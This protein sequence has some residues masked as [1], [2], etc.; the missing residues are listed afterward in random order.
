MAQSMKVFCSNSSS[1][2]ALLLILM[3]KCD[4]VTCVSRQIDILPP[5]KRV[6]RIQRNNRM[7]ATRLHCANADAIVDTLWRLDF[8]RL[9]SRVIR[10]ISASVILSSYKA[11]IKWVSDRIRIFESHLTLLSGCAWKMRGIRFPNTLFE[12]IYNF[13][14]RWNEAT[15]PRWQILP[16]SMLCSL[17]V[18]SCW[19]IFSFRSC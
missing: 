5:R 8:Y 16:L 3:H 17:Y 6:R 2:A 13:M 12:H 19:L 4:D 11:A 1:D 10:I 18:L 9:N 7:S 14:S 15:K